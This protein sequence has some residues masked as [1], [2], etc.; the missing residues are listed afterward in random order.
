MA[1]G[2]LR[3]VGEAPAHQVKAHRDEVC[4]TAV[5]AAEWDALHFAVQ[6]AQAELSER[7]GAAVSAATSTA[8]TLLTSS[9]PQLEVALGARWKAPASKHSTSMALY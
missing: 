7:A 4:V 6:S 5:T 3:V 1:Y 9:P 2:A 8:Q